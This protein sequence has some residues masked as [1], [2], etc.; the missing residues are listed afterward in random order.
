MASCE[1]Y[2]QM[3]GLGGCLRSEGID[4]RETWD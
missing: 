2:T 1:Q 3:W 4:L